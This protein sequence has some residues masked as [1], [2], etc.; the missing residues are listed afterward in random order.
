MS[1]TPVRS[2]K[3]VGL[4]AIFGTLAVAGVVITYATSS[5]AV[6]AIGFMMAI[7]FGSLVIVAQHY[8]N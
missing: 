1:T 4:A 8:Y 5:Q 6:S 3:D 2:D 7:V